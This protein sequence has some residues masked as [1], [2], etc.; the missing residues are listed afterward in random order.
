[1]SNRLIFAGAVP[2]IAHVRV[3]YSPVW[4]EYTVRVYR[5]PSELIGEY[6]TD[7]RTDAIGTAQLMLDSVRADIVGMAQLMIPALRVGA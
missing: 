1:M 6:F 4:A 7:D 2:G 5:V 3:T